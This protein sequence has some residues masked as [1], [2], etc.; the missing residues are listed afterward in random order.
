M[1]NAAEI[2]GLARSHIVEIAQP[3]CALHT[4]CVSAFLSMR[5]AAQR[6]GID[7][8]CRSSFRSFETQLSIWNAK[9]HGERTLYSREGSALQYDQLTPDQL[10]DAILIWSAIPGGSR[11][12]WGS[13]VDLIDALAV[14]EGYQV[15]LVPEEYGS[16]GIFA[17]MDEWLNQHAAEFG[18]FRPY[19]TDRGGV[20]PEPWHFS[21]APVSIPALQALTPELLRQTLLTSAIEGKPLI[22]ER[23]DEIY[24]RYLL[25]VDTP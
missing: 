17:H 4:E 16:Q 20:S 9:W 2:T 5:E 11:H 18:F 21:Y 13:D 25:A 8:Q 6:A 15:Q 7:L 19:R 10:L 24:R 14:P 12:H 22:L 23:L 3:K 1:M